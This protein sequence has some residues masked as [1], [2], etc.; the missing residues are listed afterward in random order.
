MLGLVGLNVQA[1]QLRYATPEAAAQAFF[2]AA[3]SGHPAAL[4]PVLDEAYRALGSGDPVAD[5]AELDNLLEAGAQG[6][7]IARDGE[8]TGILLIGSDEWPFPIPLVQEAEGWRF[9]TAAAR[10]EIVNRQIGRD[11]LHAI[12]TMRAIVRAQMEYSA[13]H[14]EGTEQGGYARR[15]GSTP[16]QRDGLYW[17]VGEGEPPS[18]LGPLVAAAVEEGYGDNHMEAETPYYGYFFRLLTA[19]GPNA[20]GG[21]R[22]YLQD[23]RLQGGF[24][25]VA[26]PA[27]YGR[28]G[29]K[30]FI[31]NQRGIL[32]EK[33]LG[34][35][36]AAQAKAMTAF[37]PD[38]SWEPTR[39]PTL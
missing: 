24:A 21:A 6:I 1:A 15:F 17:P 7:R 27:E 28:S 20:P 31:V 36:T 33:D 4:D 35:G 11:E 37:D 9:D 30:T 25:V 3:A 18:P 16:G 22:D 2:E 13:Q 10:T 14:A 38:A 29:I 5:A 26:Y 32:F 19:Q 34:E 39:D 23:G 12:A 8:T